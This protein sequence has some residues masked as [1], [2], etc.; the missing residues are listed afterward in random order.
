MS[1]NYRTFLPFA[2]VS[3]LLLF[4]G[5]VNP[6]VMYI[7]K[8]FLYAKKIESQLNEVRYEWAMNQVE[9]NGVLLNDISTS[10][11]VILDEG[12]QRH[13]NYDSYI[14]LSISGIIFLIGL[15]VTSLRCCSRSSASAKNK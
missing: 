15:C 11:E 6:P 10:L 8:S 7:D 1:F 2:S 13:L 3:L 14:I 9:P 12:S 4:I 5:L